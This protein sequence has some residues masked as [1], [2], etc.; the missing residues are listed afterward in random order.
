MQ[1]KHAKRDELRKAYELRL[2]AQRLL[3]SGLLATLEA[4]APAFVH[5]SYK[6]D[7]LL[8]RDL[9]INLCLA[10]DDDTASFF[11]VGAA[12]TAQYPVHKASYSNH[13]TR[14]FPGFDYGLYWGI[15][16]SFE[17]YRWKLD[18][19]G[20]GP[21]RFAEHQRRFE[22]L[23]DA[24]AHRD[25]LSILKLKRQLQAGEKYRAGITSVDIYHAVTAGVTN[26]AE[27]EKWSHL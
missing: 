2:E 8:R 10:A 4:S 5:G 19:W 22:M 25:R 14:G 24:L 11:Q 7:L 1:S 27:F 21:D 18:V 26:I 6:L 9:D 23:E 3:E 15:E 20:L 12:L 17:A 13:F 16:L